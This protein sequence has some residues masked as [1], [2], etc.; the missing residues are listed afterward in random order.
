[1]F[2]FEVAQQNVWLWLTGTRAFHADDDM[3]CWLQCP[4]VTFLS[5]DVTEAL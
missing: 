3:I 5:F 1:M 2:I 4:V